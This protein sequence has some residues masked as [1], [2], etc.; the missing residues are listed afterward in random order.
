MPVS[1]LLLSSL[2]SSAGGGGGQG[3]GIANAAGGLLSMAT[4]FF[5]RR[6]AKKELSKLQRPDYQIPNEVL[7]NKKLAEQRAAEGLP[8]QQY[9][10]AM[11]NIQRQQN[12]ALTAAGGRRGALMALPGIQQ[13]ANDAQLNL[14]VRDAQARMENQDKVY[15]MNSQLAGYRDKVYNINKLQPYQEKYNYYN[16]L[17]GAGNQNITSGIDKTAGGVGLLAGGMNFGKKKV[18]PS[19]TTNPMYANGYDEGSDYGTFETGF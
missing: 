6:K 18:K 14:D 9:N 4:G 5:Q 7:E 13:Q 8:Q 1:S 10:A 19:A 11:Q 17:L 16:S 2:M 3:Q 12:R 15:G